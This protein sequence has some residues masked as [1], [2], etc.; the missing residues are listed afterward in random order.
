VG[1]SQLMRHLEETRSLLSIV[2]LAGLMDSAARPS[3]KNRTAPM[4]AKPYDMWVHLTMIKGALASSMKR[5]RA[6]VHVVSTHDDWLHHYGTHVPAKDK[7]LKLTPR[8]R[9]VISFLL[10]GDTLKEAAQKLG[11]S[12]HTVGDHVKQIYKHFG[13]SSRAELLSHFISGGQS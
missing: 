9:Q 7:L 13:V 6:M 12:E 3:D 4:L 2:I 8:Q 1:G 10:A 5:D 11:L